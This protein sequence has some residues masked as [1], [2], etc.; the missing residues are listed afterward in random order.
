MKIE[1]DVDS[2]KAKRSLD[3]LAK[4][5]SKSMDISGKSGGNRGKSP[6]ESFGKEVKKQEIAVKSQT[7]TLTRWGTIAALGATALTSFNKNI[8]DATQNFD[9]LNNKLNSLQKR[10]DSDLRTIQKLEKDGKNVSWRKERLKSTVNQIDNQRGLVE[11]ARRKMERSKGGV[12]FFTE[13]IKDL[14]SNLKNIGKGVLSRVGLGGVGLAGATAGGIATAAAAAAIALGK[15]WHG[16]AKEFVGEGQGAQRQIERSN[17]SLGNLS[18]NL[19]GSS[20]VQDLTDEIML[21]GVNGV[22]SVE[23]LTSA[24]STL[25]MAF[26]GNKAAVSEWLPIIDDLAAATGLT[27]NQIGEL[28]AR[29]SETGEVDSRVFNTLASRGIPIYDELGKVMGVTTD[30]A[31]ELAKQGKVTAEQAEEAL[32]NLGKVVEGTS[33]ALSSKTLEGAEASFKASGELEHAGYAKGYNEERIKK[34]NTITDEQKARAADAGEQLEMRAT[35]AA[36]AWWD[37]LFTDIGEMWDDLVEGF[38]GTFA[39]IDDAAK[40]YAAELMDAANQI[41]NIG[42]D[43]YPE[44]RDRMVKELSKHMDDIDTIL[45]EKNLGLGARSDLTKTYLELLKQRRWLLDLNEDEMKSHEREAAEKEEERQRNNRWN[46]ST[47]EANQRIEK[48]KTKDELDR[49]WE[50]KL[51]YEE[52]IRDL[53]TFFDTLEKLNQQYAN[54]SIS[55]GDIEKW[56]KFTDLAKQYSEDAAKISENQKRYAEEQAKIEK[57]RLE[58]LKRGHR[59]SIL[60][61]LELGEMSGNIHAKRNEAQF[62][63]WWDLQDMEFASEEDKKKAYSEWVAKQR[64]KNLLEIEAATGNKTARAQLELSNRWN[65]INEMVGLTNSDREA[66]LDAE[67]SYRL[68]ELAKSTL[69]GELLGV[70]PVTGKEILGEYSKGNKPQSRYIN[71]AWGAACRTFYKFEKSYDKEQW[72]ELKKNTEENKK[73]AKGIQTL[74]ERFTISAQ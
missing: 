9:R 28:I 20:Y 58:D 19:T 48:A 13:G 42:Y 38:V 37:N 24:A 33:A 51:M 46:Y 8:A 40:S 39:S 56:K 43:I 63:K 54:G 64:E 12:G 35:G 72:L 47:W 30:R 49:S 50:S 2:S 65:A 45:K 69:K 68:K 74:A 10:R 59:T 1:V 34:L 41:N 55:D 61:R 71:N 11:V 27:A 15:M 14:G 44:D 18:K 36:V 31:K 7:S 53:K 4:E 17:V 29:M 73:T 25:L 32:K 57:E 6:A 3:K 70:D 66:A 16:T 67:V 22:T 26:K 23:Q 60:E 62:R 5:A 21:L 52:G